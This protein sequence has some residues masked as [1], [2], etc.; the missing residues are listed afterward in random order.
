MLKRFT[1]AVAALFALVQLAGAA[2]TIPF[3]LS[4]QLDQFGKPLA[5]GRLYLVQ[6]GTVSTPQNCFQDSALTL[7]WPNPI[8]LDASGRIGQLFCA[9]GSIK[10]RLTDKNLTTIVVA[11]NI[12]VIGASSGGGGGG[13]VDPTTILSTGDLKVSYNTG[14]LS[15]FVRANGRTIG[16]TTSGATE[17]AN[18]DCQTLFLALWNADANLVVVGG[19][20]VS[21]AADW[22]ANKQLTLPDFRSRALAG[23]GDMGNS[24]NALFSGVTFT[25]GNSTTLGSLLG[26]ARRTI[27][28]INLPA[29][30][31]T[32]NISDPGHTHANSITQAQFALSSG[33]TGPFLYG[34]SIGGGAGSVISP[35]GSNITA[36]TPLGGSGTLLETVSTYALVTI[37][38]KL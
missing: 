27:G 15:G 31:L 5:G 11:D 19:R 28:Q 6:A 30:T 37:Y 26:A 24:D 8:T 29:V 35:A 1:V 21:A 22:A 7:P 33:G 25:S 13:T 32:T 16:S 9:D 4:Q 10:I 36:S 38:L 23:L 20:G 2:G 17:R 3:S 12:Q 14:V 18:S 34:A